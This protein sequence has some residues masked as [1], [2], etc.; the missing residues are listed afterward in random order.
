M[1]TPWISGSRR[2]YSQWCILGFFFL[3]GCLP[4]ELAEPEKPVPP[5]PE[6]PSLLCQPFIKTGYTERVSYFPG[7]TMRVFFESTQSTELCRLTLYN[8]AGDS[9]FSTT[10]ALPLVSKVPGDASE[11]GFDYPVA[12]EFFVPP[13]PSGVYMIE[14][15][16]PF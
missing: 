9:V 5:A 4:E 2:F 1:L 14:K 11:Y 8:L 7:E 10:S 15:R 12:V 16:I 6:L 3:A 13:L